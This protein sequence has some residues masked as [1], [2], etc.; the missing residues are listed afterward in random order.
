MAFTIFNL[1]H[2]ILFEETEY[3]TAMNIEEANYK[4]RNTYLI[5]IIQSHSTKAP[6]Y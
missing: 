2:L 4:D 1:I 6:N 3:K 5:K